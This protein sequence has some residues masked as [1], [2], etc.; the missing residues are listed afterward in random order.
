MPPIILLDTCFKKATNESIFSNITMK[1]LDRNFD[2]QSLPGA[3]RSQTLV[4]FQ[5]T[6]GS[7]QIIIFLRK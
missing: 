1:K 5:P 6:H 7:L 2:P 4:L 3:K